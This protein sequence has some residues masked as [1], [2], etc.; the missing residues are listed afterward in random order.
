[1]KVSEIMPGMRFGRLTVIAP[2]AATDSKRRF[3]CKCDCGNSKTILGYSLMGKTRSCGCLSIEKATARL[4]AARGY[5]EQL[6]WTCQKA[7]GGCQWSRRGKPID[8][9]DAKPAV[10]HANGVPLPSYA[11]VGCPEYI[12]D[13][14]KKGD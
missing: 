2:A 8:G 9:W 6:C 3:V 12:T 14:M 11:I 5:T 10:V 1:M 4:N 7:T 13:E